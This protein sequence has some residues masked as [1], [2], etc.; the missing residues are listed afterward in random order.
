MIYINPAYAKVWGRSCESL[1]ENPDSFTDAIW[2]EDKPMVRLHYERYL[3]SGEFDCEYRI[4]RPDGTIRWI[5]AQSFPV[6]NEAG[7]VIRHAGIAAEITERKWQDRCRQSRIEILNML[8]GPADMKETMAGVLR[9]LKALTGVSAAGI[10]LREGDDFPYVAHDGFPDSFI[11]TENTLIE[12]DE[13]GNP[14]RDEKGQVLLQCTCGLVI[15][16]KTDPANT[17]FTVGGSCWTNNS[18]PLLDL[19]ADQ[20][21]R[22]HPRNNCMRHGYVSIAIIPIKEGDAVVGTVQ[23]NDVRTNCFNMKIIEELE[24]IASHI[25]EALMRQKNE[26]ELKRTTERAE[27]AN[28][29]KSEFLANMSHEIRTP[30]NGVIGMIDLLL[31][32]ELADQQRRYAEMVKSSGESLLTV[33]NDV[34]DFSKIEAGKLKI[35]PK[36]FDIQNEVQAVSEMI[37]LQ[38]R[39]KGL[40]I[41]HTIAS[42]VP[43][44]L[45]GDPARLRQILLNLTSNAVKFTEKGE[46][47]LQVEPSKGQPLD[48]KVGTVV[49]VRFIVRDTG[50]GISEEGIR[51]LFQ[52]FSQVDGSMTRQHGGTGLGLAI[53]KQLVELMGGEVGVESEV[54]KG[55]SFWFTIPLQVAAD[56]AVATLEQEA[57]KP[58]MGRFAGHRVRLLLV[59]DVATNRTLAHELLR[60]LG[61]AD[62]DIVSDGFEALAAVEQHTYDLVLMD[63]QMPK[64]DGLETTRRLRVQTKERARSVVIAMTA[65]AMEGDREKCIAA[66]MDDYITKPLSVTALATVLERWLPPAQNGDSR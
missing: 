12:R 4:V 57:K 22:L 56:P 16:G 49:P 39:A 52:Q 3:E 15:S 34:L 1:Y 29:A 37:S 48:T 20:D 9:E 30:M 2:D 26:Y 59:D 27:R 11:K 44:Y 38:A 36:D 35:Q 13:H 53:S 24:G 23:L 51:R 28:R 17:L 7:E 58:L 14:R 33:L 55:S 64:L 50:V 25:G 19:P 46:V 18:F 43:R 61:F 8:N 21:P 6:R 40:T 65:H 5:R 63:V 10:R 45:V 66:G 60:L 62:V 31:R 42:G 54:G 41:H 47:S 32:T